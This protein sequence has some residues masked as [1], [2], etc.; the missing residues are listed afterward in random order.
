MFLSKAKVESIFD[1]VSNLLFTMILLLN[2]G[3][4]RIGRNDGCVCF[5]D[6]LTARSDRQP[7]LVSAL[8]GHSPK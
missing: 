1:V 7:S 3:K 4:I 5:C 6:V 8:H 2:I